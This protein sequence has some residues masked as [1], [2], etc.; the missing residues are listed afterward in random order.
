MV[1]GRTIASIIIPVPHILFWFRLY[2]WMKGNPQFRN[3]SED[4]EE[5]HV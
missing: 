5:L 2:A 3:F 1:G 4:E